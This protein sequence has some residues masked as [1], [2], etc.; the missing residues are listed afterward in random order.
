MYGRFPS[1]KE[2]HACLDSP[3]RLPPVSIQHLHEKS[4]KEPHAAHS[5]LHSQELFSYWGCPMFIDT[6]LRPSLWSRYHSETRIAQEVLRPISW[7]SKETVTWSHYQTVPRWTLQAQRTEAQWRSRKQVKRSNP[8]REI[9]SNRR[10][11]QTK[12]PYR[13]RGNGIET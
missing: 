2:Y 10:E 6:N 7:D 5:N 4:V 3:P 9:R 13:L 12:E 1:T 8:L 11:G